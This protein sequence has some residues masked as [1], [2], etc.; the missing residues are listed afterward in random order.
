VIG[1]IFLIVLL[2]FVSIPILSGF[3]QRLPWLRV[4]FLKNLYWYHMVFAVIYY[5][6]TM[7][8]AS[9]SVAYYWM[10]MRY[11]SWFEAYATGT[12]FIH[13]VA[14]PFTNYLMFTYEMMMVF[15]A[16]LGYWGFVYFYIVFKENIQFKHQ[17][18]GVDLITLFIFLPNM[19]YWT[20]SLGKGSII[21]MGMAMAIYG[22]SK[23]NFRKIP[24]IIGLII[25]YQV[26]P[27]VFLFMAVGIL[28]GIFTGRQKVPFYQKFLVFTGSIAALI[29]LSDTIFAF[30]GLDSDNLIDSFN[31]LSTH[32]AFELSKAGSGID[33][34]NY[35]LILK[36]LTFWF[37]PLF[38]DAPSFI[39]IIVSFENLLYVFLTIKLFDKQFLSFIAKAPALI[40]TSAVT[41][42]AT[43]FA[44][45][46]TLSNLGIII[47]QKSMVMYFLLMLILCFMDYKKSLRISRKKKWLER[48]TPAQQ[49]QLT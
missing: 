29:I 12:K 30:A 41:F 38:F 33:T 49:V 22:L 31:Q 14:F 8:S 2:Y 34:S 27:H 25:V 7:S 20:A 48:S 13:F 32:R 43:S 3:R 16:W 39:G 42:L 24:L 19:H 18:Y 5:V 11:P 37:R 1:A 6:M 17:L 23:L 47:R 35:P 10:S 9:D 44:L 46:G 21:F 4:Q 15:F 40:K 26:R 45:S 36:L 28:L